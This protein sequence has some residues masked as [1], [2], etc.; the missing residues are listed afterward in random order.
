MRMTT[1]T[2]RFL[3]ASVALLVAGTALSVGCGCNGAQPCRDSGSAN[4]DGAGNEG[5]G[6]GEGDD[7]KVLPLCIVQDV[8]LPGNASRF[9]YEDI[10]AEH[11]Q[12]VI[13]HMGDSEVVVVDVDDLSVKGTVPNVGVVRGA[14]AAPSVNRLFATASSTDELVIIDADAISEIG[15]VATGGGPDGIAFDPIDHVV[16]VSAQHAGEVTLFADDG[17]GA[18]VD[19]AVGNDT[20][21]TEFHAARG[22]FF[23]T[24]TSPDQLVEITPAGEVV[25]RI[26]IAGCSGAHGLRFAPDGKSALIACEVNATLAR[27]AL[28]DDEHA[29][30]TAGTGFAPDVLSID[31]GFGWIYVAAE[32]GDLKIFDLA[33]GALTEIDSEHPGDSAHSVAVDPTTHRAFFPLENGGDGPV[34]RVMKPSSQSGS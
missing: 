7:P 6:E 13:A 9:D 4:G 31:P 18:R 2:S 27:V 17:D 8:A 15:R 16:A 30:I 23:A 32:S 11:R 26:D 12:L 29:V 14:I 10:D 22:N 20:G 1:A 34:L 19:V 21:N 5:E 24:V 33:G 28:D 3:L 25:D